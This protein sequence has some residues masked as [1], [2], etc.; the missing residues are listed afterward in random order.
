M[1]RLELLTKA[2]EGHLSYE[3]NELIKE[4]LEL[5]KALRDKE[6]SKQRYNK[7]SYANKRVASVI[8][9]AK[10]FLKA[11]DKMLEEYIEIRL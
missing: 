7:V 4:S 9:I 8:S 6:I 3:Y 2:L 1:E 10:S 11:N 5:S